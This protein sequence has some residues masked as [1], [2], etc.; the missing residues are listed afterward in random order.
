MLESFLKKQFNFAAITL[1]LLLNCIINAQTSGPSTPEVQSFEPINMTNMVNLITGDF[2][3]NIPLLSIPNAP[4]GDFPINI[5]YQAGITYDQEASWVGLGWNINVGSIVRNKSGYPDDYKSATVNQS[6]EGTARYSH[7]L[8]LGFGPANLSWSGHTLKG[9]TFQGYSFS[10]SFSSNTTTYSDEGQ[11]IATK[12]LGLARPAGYNTTNNSFSSSNSGGAYNSFKSMLNPSAG[13]GVGFQGGSFNTHM[14]GFSIGFGINL[15]IFNL[16]SISY[17]STKYWV[18]G[19]IQLNAYGY[20]NTDHWFDEAPWKDENHN[21][22]EYSYWKNWKTDYY[23]ASDATSDFKV[24]MGTAEDSY[25]LQ[26]EWLTGVFKPFLLNNMPYPPSN[27]NKNIATL[28]LFSDLYTR[29]PPGNST[30]KFRFIND[31]GGLQD[32]LDYSSNFPGYVANENVNE[33]SKNIEPRYNG[34]LL[35]GF[36][37]TDNDGTIYEFNEPVYSNFEGYKGQNSSETEYCKTEMPQRYAYAWL[38]SSIKSSDYYDL[39]DDGPTDDDYGNWIKFNYSLIHSNYEWRTPSYGVMS[40]GIIENNDDG[41]K[42]QYTVSWGL[43]EIKYLSKAET[44]THVVFFDCSDRDDGLCI[45][46]TGNIGSKKLKQLDNIFLYN[47]N[48]WSDLNSDGIVDKNEVTIPLKNINFEYNYELALGS[49]NSDSNHNGTPGEFIDPLFNGPGDGRLTLKKI[50]FNGY[51]YSMSINPILSIPPYSFN[52][53]TLALHTFKDN[54]DNW[55]YYCS[56]ASLEDHRRLNTINEAQTWSLTEI[57]TPQGS[58]INITYEDK[59]YSNVNGILI[60]NPMPNSIEKIGGGI[61]VK[62]LSFIDYSDNIYQNYKYF[63]GSA[64]QEPPPY[65]PISIDDRVSDYKKEIQLFRLLDPQIFYKKVQVYESSIFDGNSIGYT[66]YNNITP[67]DYP[68]ERYYEDL[69]QGSQFFAIYKRDI[70]NGYYGLPISIKK[71]DKNN[72]LI[73]D[74][75]FSYSHAPLTTYWKSSEGLTNYQK[76]I[77]HINQDYMCNFYLDPTLGMDLEYFTYGIDNYWFPTLTSLTETKDGVINYE[78]FY[79]FDGRTGKPVEHRSRKSDGRFYVYRDEPA[80]W[81]YLGMENQNMLIQPFSTKLYID[82]VAAQNLL[83]ESV[84]TWSNGLRRG[85]GVFYKQNDTYE[86]VNTFPYSEFPSD[87]IDSDYR[88]YVTPSIGFPWQKTSNITKFDN[89][90]HILEE[91]SADA[92]YSCSKYA[93]NES[94]PEAIVSNAKFYE[95]GFASLESGWGEWESGNSSISSDEKKTGLQSAYCI[96][97]YGPTKNFAVYDDNLFG[98]RDDFLSRNRTYVLEAWVKRLNG[99]AKI[100]IERRDMNDNIIAP[101]IVQT[102]N[103]GSDWQ[104]VSIKI[105]PQELTVVPNRGYLRVWCGFPD[106]TNNNGYVDDV[107]FK[108]LDASMITYTYDKFR[109]LTSI[110]DNNINTTFYE[111]DSAGR[112][113]QVRDN[114]K[115]IVKQYQY[116]YKRFNQT[117]VSVKQE[118]G[119]R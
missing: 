1:M 4:K 90:D 26:S 28:M 54:W 69:Q 58:N 15:G 2:I 13:G 35:T 37:V 11:S 49:D 102:I 71:F 114:D 20:L 3:Y 55:G 105:T 16:F 43:K 8:S 65:G 118:G 99:T 80:Y 77:S 46:S 112:L 110:T 57:E 36:T 88:G 116:N 68:I 51:D 63:D 27:F 30:Y 81:H 61:R 33:K 47:K 64:T 31:G 104:F 73:Y 92:T 93:Y 24:S 9:M 84:T 97:S 59:H 100:V 19:D 56:R 22:K 75:E 66:E 12:N 103:S 45:L 39:E 44:R 111:Y 74:K 50:F 89:F 52:Y 17:S 40:A 23:E 76:S 117:D 83:S 101:S 41:F 82:N 91:S 98:D 113:K 32:D 6:M 78:D 29:Y 10:L 18:E 95:S 115:N 109:N 7:S 107:R 67:S 14:S 53:N 85:V 21:L 38:L 25:V 108:P 48:T 79:S 5:F 62:N 96:S 70:Y 42:S 106:G 94:L 87:S 86:Y 72:N 60:N 34:F 119:K